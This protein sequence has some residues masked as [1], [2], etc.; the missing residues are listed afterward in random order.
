MSDEAL[1]IHTWEEANET[2]VEVGR[3]D[4]LIDDFT[5]KMNEQIDAIKEQF[6]AQIIPLKK[7]RDQLEQ[8]LKG[9]VDKHRAEMKGKSRKMNFGK[10][11]YRSSSTLVIDDELTTMTKL[12]DLG[13]KSCIK[14]KESIDKAELKKQT[15]GLLTQVGA[16]IDEDERFYCEPDKQLIEIFD[17]KPNE[18]KAS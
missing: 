13:M 12:R 7:E 5:I 14:M 9:F 16:H 8:E 2:L 1:L 18:K 3:T 10:V 4:R 11:G 6:E 15:E 17:K